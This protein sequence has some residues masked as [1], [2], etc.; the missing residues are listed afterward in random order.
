MRT[1]REIY[2]ELCAD[3]S[4]RS[5]TQLVSG[6]DM[7][8]R[9]WA[10]A[11][12]VYTLEAQADF[13]TRQCFP[14][15]AVGE[16]L[17]MH[18]RIRA[19]ERGKA[20]KAVG[21]VRFYLDEERESNTRIAAG[22]RCMSADEDE[23]IT[24]GPGLIPAGQ[25]WCDVEAEAVNPGARGNIAAGSICLMVLAPV[26]IAGVTNTAAFTGGCDAEED[27]ALRQRVVNSY[28]TLPNG[29]NVAYY[30]TK[31]MGCDGVAAVTVQP[32]KRGRGTVDICFATRSGIPRAEEIEAVRAMLDSEREI[33][34][35]IAVS[36]PAEVR[37]NVSAALTLDTNSDAAEVKK[38]AQEAVRA[39]FGGAMLGRDIYRA[40]LLSALMAV[41]GVE[42]CAL[43]A[44]SEDVEISPVEL[45]VLGG[46]EIRTAV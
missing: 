22:V 43:D 26:G 6:G 32:K 14:Q 20:K 7:S 12:E 27:D 30:E 24:T 13:V 5:G 39:C 40:K 23:F 38:R 3:F 33:C 21:Q 16:Y 1:I 11:G 29:A 41:Q 28:R 34:V 36:A 9:L 2:D 42:N 35:D 25:K 10:V 31:V 44:P 17:D 19:L 15:T 18:A 46:L 37:V 45:P 8:L 4:A